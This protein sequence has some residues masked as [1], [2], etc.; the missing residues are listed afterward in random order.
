M[1]LLCL[2][3]KHLLGIKRDT[4]SNDNGTG[5]SI[6]EEE[7]SSMRSKVEYTNECQELNSAMFDNMSM[8]SVS[9]AGRSILTCTP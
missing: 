4:G 8:W 5:P 7:K 2:R 9:I 3:K 1:T 6:D